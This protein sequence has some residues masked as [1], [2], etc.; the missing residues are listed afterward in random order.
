MYTVDLELLEHPRGR[1]PNGI[2]IGSF[3]RGGVISLRAAHAVES[4]V[5]A[6]QPKLRLFSMY[7]LESGEG[8][9]RQAEPAGQLGLRGERAS[10]GDERNKK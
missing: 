6:E 5:T 7:F 4:G 10:G 9:N 8:G 3:G 1:C 2:V